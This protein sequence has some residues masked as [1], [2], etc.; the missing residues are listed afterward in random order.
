MTNGQ[1][2][3]AKYY[4]Y[5]VRTVRKHLGISGEN[6]SRILGHTRSYVGCIENG[7]NKMSLHSY[8]YMK[9]VLRGM[10][11]LP[12][13]KVPAVIVH[14]P[15]SGQ[16]VKKLRR[17]LGLTQEKFAGLLGCHYHTVRNWELGR[18]VMT[19]KG[20][21]LMDALLRRIGERAR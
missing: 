11:T 13:A 3:G 15:Y 12:G 8:I 19:P 6:L 18:T 2:H 16:E 21:C 9:K 14:T 10:S 5:I 4:A 17:R 1:P 7:S 20:V